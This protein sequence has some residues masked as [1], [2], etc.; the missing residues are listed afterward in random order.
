MENLKWVKETQIKKNYVC[1]VATFFIIPKIMCAV[2]LNI[3]TEAPKIQPGNKQ[4]KKQEV[5]ERI[6]TSYTYIDLNLQIVKCK[7]KQLFSQKLKV[8]IKCK[9][10][11]FHPANSY[12]SISLSNFQGKIHEKNILQEATNLLPETN[13]FEVKMYLLIKKT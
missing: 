11:I 2:H 10:K 13:V 6:L 4:G 12:R 9:V 1:I 7:V 3:L 5:I 8:K